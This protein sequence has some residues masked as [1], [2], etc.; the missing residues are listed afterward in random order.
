MALVIGSD[1]SH[2]SYTGRKL[3]NTT[4]TLLSCPSLSDLKPENLLLDEEGLLKISDFGL[5]ALF[6]G[7]G[8]EDGR[9]TLL[10]TTCGTP[11]Y[12]APEV[13]S[14]KGYDG[15]AAD[16]WSCGVI[17]YV[18]LAGFLPFDEPHMSALFRKIQKADFSYPSWITAEARALIDKILV[19]D[20][21]RRLTVEQVAADPWFTKNM[22][23]E[24]AAAVSA[25]D[26]GTLVHTPSRIEMEGAVQ[27][28][29]AGAEEGAAGA[30]EATAVPQ[31]NVFQVVNVLGGMALNK[32][33]ATS[34]G[35]DAATMRCK[36]FFSPLPLATVMERSAAVLAEAGCTVE[37]G[38]YAVTGAVHTN[39]GGAPVEGAM[40]LPALGQVKITVEAQVV[41][42]GVHVIDVRKLKGDSLAYHKIFCQVQPKLKAALEG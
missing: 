34:S 23:S 33:L 21:A 26:A 18:L 8:D 27:D 6:S 39:A 30:D 12:V 29:P 28:V 37:T 15:R 9:A 31:A 16:V 19:V 35:S 4:A 22:D 38:S 25:A 13:L 40:P 32:M 41:A 17:L 24:S 7:G 11:N 42:D 5:S 1:P 14:D 2:L 20:P 36:H 3:T 10:H